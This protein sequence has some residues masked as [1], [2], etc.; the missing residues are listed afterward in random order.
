M[1][2]EWKGLGKKREFPK[3]S[4]TLYLQ[5]LAKL[6]PDSSEL[7]FRYT[8][9]LY[10]GMCELTAKPECVSATSALFSAVC[11]NI[12]RNLIAFP[13]PQASLVRNVCT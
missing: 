5:F 7:R 2:D 11:V 8:S 12:Q 13:L 4:I 1:N 9:P 3:R 10:C 6:G